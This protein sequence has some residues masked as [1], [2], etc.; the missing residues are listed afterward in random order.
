[1]ESQEKSFE[2]HNI[3]YET[4]VYTHNIVLNV[5]NVNNFLNKHLNQKRKE[6]EGDALL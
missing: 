3:K 2:N 4:Y 5:G 6:S 1:M